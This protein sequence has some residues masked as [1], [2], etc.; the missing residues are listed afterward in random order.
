MSASVHPK[1]IASNRVVF[2][3]HLAGACQPATFNRHLYGDLGQIDC[4][5]GP[6]GG[7]SNRQ[8]KHAF[9]LSRPE[10]A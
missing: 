9:T 5:P 2:P 8:A 3:T 1:A 4:D 7:N 6:D 10:V